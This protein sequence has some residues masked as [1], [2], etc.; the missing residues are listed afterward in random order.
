MARFEFSAEDV[1]GASGADALFQL[2]LMYCTGRE[3]EMDLVQAH[4]WFNLAALRGNE[5]A[6]QYRLEISREMTK[7][8]I[9]AAQKSAREW[10]K[11]H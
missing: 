2:G 4:K 10:L 5:S 3:V 6:K 9:A 8:D 11:L 1:V 7:K